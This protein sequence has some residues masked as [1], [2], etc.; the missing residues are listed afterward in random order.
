MALN[1]A[2]VNYSRYSLEMPCSKFEL[3]SLSSV[4]LKISLLHEKAKTFFS[5][6]ESTFF[7]GMSSEKSAFSVRK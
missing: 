7:V 6:T 5:H 1:C 3:G 2:C 4:F